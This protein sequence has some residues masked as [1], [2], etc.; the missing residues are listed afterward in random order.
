MNRYSPFTGATVTLPTCEQPP[1]YVYWMSSPYRGAMLAEYPVA[2]DA[3]ERVAFA[4]PNWDGYGALPVSAEAKKNALEAVR[5]ILP[6]APTPEINPNPNG[7]LSFEW[8][9]NLGNA[10]LEIGQTRYSFY[11]NPR[12]GPPIFLE[13]EV[14]T[15]HRLHG[16]LV[17]SLLY[18]TS[19]TAGTMTEVRRAA[20]VRYS[21]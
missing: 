13:G 15:V 12:V 8:G 21:D 17:A 19:S 9:T 6:V 10:H 2:F 3:I 7:T 16:S 5:V 4:N 1:P 20:D 14:E 18:P 11:V